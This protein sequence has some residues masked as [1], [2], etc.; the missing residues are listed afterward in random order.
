MNVLSASYKNIF[1]FVV[2]LLIGSQ[3]SCGFHLRGDVRLSKHIQ[4]L[5][6]DLDDN[7]DGVGRELSNLLLASDKNNLTVSKEEAKAI[8]RI[9]NIQKTRRVVTVD[10]FGRASEYELNYQFNYELKTV[11]DADETSKVIKRNL[12]RLKRDLVFDP[13]SVLVASN[14]NEALYDDMRKDAAQSVLRQ[15]SFVKRSAKQ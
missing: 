8:L 7:A 15:L 14:E 10:N 9:F 1:I 4:P 5:F 2:M 3:V 11:P 12:V 6:I 13:G